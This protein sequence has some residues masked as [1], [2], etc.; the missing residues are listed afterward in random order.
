MGKLIIL[1]NTR[2]IQVIFCV[3]F[4]RFAFLAQRGVQHIASKPIKKDGKIRCGLIYE[5]WTVHILFGD[6]PHIKKYKKG[7]KKG[8]R[9]LFF[10]KISL[11]FFSS[12]SA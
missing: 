2:K 8:D 9:L 3:M 1:K 11:P 7:D 10:W 5:K 12:L 4:S 6:Y